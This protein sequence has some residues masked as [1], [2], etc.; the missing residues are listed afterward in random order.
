[1]LE[2]I[3]KI[4]ESPFLM[5]KTRK[6]FNI[7]FDWFVLPNNFPKVLEGNYSD[8]PRRA[9]AETAGADT[10]NIFLKIL[11]EERGQK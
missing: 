3:G 11:E 2:A 5:G 4:Q 8:R 6:P 9:S 10:N 1:V 7:T